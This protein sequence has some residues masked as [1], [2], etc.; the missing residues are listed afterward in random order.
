MILG[1]PLMLGM[2]RLLVVLQWYEA[3]TG[4]AWYEAITGC[5]SYVANISPVG[6]LRMLII[7]PL[8]SVDLLS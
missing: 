6:L 8:W 1:M 2:W 3:I 5:A 4:C 7:S